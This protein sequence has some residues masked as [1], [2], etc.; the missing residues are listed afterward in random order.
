MILPNICYV[1]GPSE[2]SYWLQIKEMFDQEKVPFPILILRDTVFI[3]KEKIL[4]DLK[5]WD[6]I[7]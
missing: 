2:V 5:I 4:K 1:G 7:L 3:A 6:L